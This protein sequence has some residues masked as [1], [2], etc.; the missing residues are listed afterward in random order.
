MARVKERRSIGS[1]VASPLNWDE[2]ALAI[3]MSVVGGVDRATARALL[4][5]RLPGAVAQA[6]K[7]ADTFFGIEVPALAEWVFGSERAAA[8][9]GD[10]RGIQCGWPVQQRIQQRGVGSPMSV[11][12]R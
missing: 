6:I 5:E 2:R 7:D 9:H 3:F 10:E 12:V 11:I 4:E 1:I 8:S